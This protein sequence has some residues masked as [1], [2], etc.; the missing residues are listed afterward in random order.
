MGIQAWIRGF[1]GTHLFVFLPQAIA[2]TR[3][4][5]GH[6]VA[7]ERFLWMTKWYCQISGWISSLIVLWAGM[8]IIELFYMPGKKNHQHLLAPQVGDHKDGLFNIFWSDRPGD[9]WFE[10]LGWMIWF[11]EFACWFMFYWTIKDA[12]QYARYLIASGADYESETNPF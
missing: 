5:N 4:K 7:A 11:V 9:V 1:T 3:A 10:I 8:L 12:K 2:W 6:Q